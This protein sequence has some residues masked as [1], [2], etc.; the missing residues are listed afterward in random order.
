MSFGARLDD[1]LEALG[2]LPVDLAR[3][4][5]MGTSTVS[6]LRNGWTVPSLVTALT[7][8]EVTGWTIDS[9]VSTVALGGPDFARLD[10]PVHL[11]TTEWGKAVRRL[12]DHY[13]TAILASIVGQC[14]PTVR[15]YYLNGIEP[16]LRTAKRY[17]DALGQSL[18]DLALGTPRLP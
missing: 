10:K 3:V 14:K 1:A 4:S 5:G 2:W 18:Q 15:R 12:C 8:S 6:H 16:D 13:T 11:A 9:L 7:I 17:S